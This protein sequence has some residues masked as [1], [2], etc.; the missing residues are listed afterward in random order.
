VVIV[1]LDDVGYAQVGCYG[2]NIDTPSFD[3]LAADGLRFANFHTTSLCSPTRA[4]LMTGRN[5]HS[6]G[7]A[8]VVEF[9]SGFPGYDADIPRENGLLSEILLGHDYATFAV[10]KWH[11]TPS[12]EMTM[13]SRRDKWPLGRG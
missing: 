11:M 13:G 6:N 10:G 2:S 1:V 8:R 4:A 12:T 7:M 5:H 9:A 3:G